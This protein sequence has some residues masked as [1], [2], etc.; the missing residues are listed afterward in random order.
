MVQA[1]DQNLS[2]CHSRQAMVAFKCNSYDDYHSARSLLLKSQQMI[3]KWSGLMNEITEAEN[4]QET[5]R[6]YLMTRRRRKMRVSAKWRVG[7][8]CI[9]I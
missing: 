6:Q 5:L 8:N 4:N 2:R 3:Q 9:L 1:G 7:T